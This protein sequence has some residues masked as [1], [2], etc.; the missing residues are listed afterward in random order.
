MPSITKRNEIDENRKKIFVEWEK[1]HDL[2]K[3]EVEALI[4][5]FENIKTIP[6]PQFQ[7]LTIKFYCIHL[8]NYFLFHIRKLLVDKNKNSE[9]EKLLL[10][11]FTNTSNTPSP[12]IMYNLLS[13]LVRNDDT[14][15]FLCDSYKKIQEL[16]NKYAHGASN[17]TS[18]SITTDEYK[19]IYDE[20]TSLN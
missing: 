12:T 18:L 20:I 16:R 19:K 8:C 6:N 3:T 1:S 17:E 10:N 9:A 15:N 14:L 2:I 7:D 13:F 4:S 5:S 11:G